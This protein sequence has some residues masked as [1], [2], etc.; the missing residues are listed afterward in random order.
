MHS[1]LVKA[2]FRI[3]SFAS[4]FIPSEALADDLR[5]NH[6]ESVAVSD[7]LVLGRPIVVAEH[8]L[9]EVA[10]KMEWFGADIGA[11]E[12]ALEETPKVFQSV[13]VDLPINVTFGMVND[14][15]NK[16][17]VQSLIREQ[18]IGVDRTTSRNV[19]SDFALDRVFAPI[20]NDGRTDFAA[21]FQD[22]HD[23]SFVLSA[24]L[25]D[26]DAA[27]VLVHEASRATDEGF[28][29]FNFATDFPEGLIL[30]GEANPVEHEPCGLLGY[31]ESASHFVGTDSVFAV[32]EHPSSGEPFVETDRG[33]LKDGPNF[34][35]E[36]ALGM[37]S[38]ALP[39]ATR[40]AE[41][42]LFGA[43]S[44]AGDTFGPAPRNEVIEAVVGV[45][46][47]QDCFLQALGFAH[48]LGLHES[49]STLKLWMSQVNY[50]LHK[51]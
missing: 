30:Q 36:L 3:R 10:E 6:A 28:V 14:L 20:R 9:V 50:C 47:V 15:M 8:L 46:E 42:D 29:Y 33:I 48:G 11:F 26:A 24:S 40:S 5:D 39:D 17:L 16:I 25:G 38:G 35:G 43:A 22:S 41:R 27:L 32:S 4:E 23:R 19:V 45:R 2:R 12:T 1:L 13:G 34:D 44:R 49:N 7:E 21:T 18:R 31:L 51:Y 37:V